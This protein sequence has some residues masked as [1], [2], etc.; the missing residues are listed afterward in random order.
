[1]TDETEPLDPLHLLMLVAMA[2]A[3]AILVPLA[4]G[5]EIGLA[6]RGYAIGAGP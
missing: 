2:L 6:A 5:F 1:M 4:C 3:V